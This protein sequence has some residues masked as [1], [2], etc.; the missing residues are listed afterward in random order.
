M[1]SNAAN[2]IAQT[3]GRNIRDARKARGMTQ[4]EVGQVI[5]VESKDVSRWESG[6]VEPNVERRSKLA[7]LF[8]D[9]SIAALYAEPEELG[10]A[11]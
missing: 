11:A 10:A 9:G 2:Q 6:L 4:R 7:D 3:V 5:G 1:S 8:F